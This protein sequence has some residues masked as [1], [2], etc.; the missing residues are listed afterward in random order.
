[1]SP[2]IIGMEL[3]DS[4]MDKASEKMEDDKLLAQFACAFI[5]NMGSDQ[6]FTPGCATYAFNNAE[7]ML[8]EYKKRVNK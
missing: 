5:T 1:M 7:I 2:Q 3:L 8:A 4:L 6:A